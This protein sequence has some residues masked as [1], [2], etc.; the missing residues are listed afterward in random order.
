MLLGGT[1]IHPF[2]HVIFLAAIHILPEEAR[3]TSQDFIKFWGNFF[4]FCFA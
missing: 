4:Y 3:V 2:N 1:D